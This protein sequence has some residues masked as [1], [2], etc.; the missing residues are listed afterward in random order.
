MTRR[1]Q[2]IS[3][4][5]PYIVVSIGLYLFHNAWIAFIAYHVCMLTFI[6]AYGREGNL[7]KLFSGWNWFIAIPLAVMSAL[8]ILLA[9][10][11]RDHMVIDSEKM[12]QTLS[13]FGLGKIS[14][15]VFALLF[16][17][18]HP[19]LEELFWRSFHWGPCRTHWPID[20]VFAGYHV[21]VMVFFVK[22][23]GS[24]MIFA[25]IA[26]V[27]ILWRFCAE[28]LNGL[29]TVFFSHII[30]DIAI[31]TSAILLAGSR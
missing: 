21:L 20:V 14:F 23:S 3:L 6:I 19:F 22:W 31:L 1:V 25:I 30:A 29:A 2:L 7:K 8:I 24:L 16:V 11:I 15:C 28:K 4:A 9:F 12:T 27:A 10:A 17:S 18:L 26:A 5:A 13:G